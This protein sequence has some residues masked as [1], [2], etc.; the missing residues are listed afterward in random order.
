AVKRGG[1]S[2]Q[3][4]IQTGI[5]GYRLIAERTEKY[6]PG[7]EP[8]YIEDEKGELI[9][10]TAYVKKLINNEW[11]EVAATARFTEYKQEA[12][13]LWPKMPYLML[14]KCAESLALR[15]AFPA[16]MCG[17]YTSD[18]MPQGL[19][20]KSKTQ[21]ATK[22]PQSKSK[23]AESADG[24]V[25]GFITEIKPYSGVFKSGKKKGEKYT[26]YGI[27]IDDKTYG[28]FDEELGTFAQKCVGSEVEIQFEKNGDFYNALNIIPITQQD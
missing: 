26:K 19:S 8:S 22:P 6:A 28:T 5:D 14:A 18:E 24:T 25:T 16:E 15:R 9:S 7:I 4:T 1:S 12:S 13:F 2:N 20:N 23:K 10:A 21:P 27:I 17:V 11:H 3:M